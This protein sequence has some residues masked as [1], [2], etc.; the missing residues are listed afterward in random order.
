MAIKTEFINYKHYGEC[1]RLSNGDVE[2]V[3]SI[4]VGPRILRYAYTH[5][6]NILCNNEKRFTPSTS[7]EFEKYY[8][9]GKYFNL[10]GGHR[11]WIS[12]EYYPEMYYPD[13]DP[14]KYELLPNGLILTPPP[15]EENGIQMSWRI[16][17]DESGT[18]VEVEHTV[19]NFGERVKEFAAWA[20]SICAEGGTEIIPLNT[21]HVKY[22]PNARIVVWPYTDLRSKNIYLGKKYATIRQPEEGAL[23]LGFDLKDGKVYYVLEDCVFTKQYAPNYP[24]GE[25]P[26]KGASFETYSCAQFT[27]LETLSE[28][29]KIATGQSIVHTEKWSLT[30]KP[31]DFDPTDDDSIDSFVS[32]L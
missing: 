24:A 1:I 12:P 19:T 13:N 10:Y 21:N 31:C 4:G 7:P 23:K 5:G 32:K 11:L 22:L 26:D 28:L 30:K 3:V 2:L 9:E 17:M 29:K 25:Y 8:G 6:P 20:L 18:G 16:T 15:Q 14:V 27:E